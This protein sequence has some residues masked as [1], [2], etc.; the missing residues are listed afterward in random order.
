MLLR[1]RME[2]EMDAELRF[3]IEAYADDLARRGISREEALRRARI[4]FGGVERVKEEGREARGVRLLEEL[5]QDLRYGARMFRKSPG[6]T[7]VAI[8][9]L[10]LGIGAN[11][12]IF[13]VVNAVLLSP[14]PYADAHRLILVKEVLPNTSAEPFNVSGPDIAEIQRLNHV[15]E[16][17]GGFRVWTYEFSGRG[18]PARVT[19]NR[20]SSNLFD[21]LGVQPVAGRAF[22][23]QEEQFGHQVVVLSYG[24]WQRQFGGQHDVLGQTINLDRKPYTIVGVMP[25]SFVFPLPG[26]MQGVAADLWVPLGL[27]KEELAN[28][29]DNLSYTVVGRL[30]P[31]I[32]PGQVNADLQLVARGV[33]ETYQRWSR[34]ASQPLGD[35]RLG[36]VSVP[37]R[38]EVTGPLK[39]MLLMLLGAVG[40]V[41]LIACVNVANLLMMRSVGRQKE[42]AVRLAIGAGR[43]RLLRQLLVECM[44][45]AF[46]GGGLG[47]ALAVW[48]KDVLV[49]HMPASVPQF[50]AIEHDWTV[51]LFSFLLVTFA[52]LAFSALPALWASRTDFSA[53]L[54]ESGRGNSQGPDHQRLRAAFVIVEVALSAMLLV[55]AGLMVRSFQRVLNTNPGFRPEHVLTASIDLPPTEEYSQDEKVASF[56]KQLMEKLRQTPGIA[57]AGAST[58]LP[59]L[60]GWTHAF[61]VEGYQPPPGPELSLGHHSVIYGDY[62]QT[63]GI[64]LLQGRYFTEQD[65]P[66][67]THVLIVSESLA[68]K[69]WSGQNP[70]GKRLK[71]GPPESTDPW[72]TVV[73]IVGNVKQGPLETAT[74]THTYEPYAQ[75]GVPFSLRVAVRGQGDPARLAANVRAVVWSLD[76]QLALGS[77]RTMD[78]V[79]SRSTAS[80]RF[81]LVLLGAFAA[82]ALVLAAIGIYAVLAYSVA[83][84]THEIG[85]RMALGARTGDV[86][87]LVLGQGLRLTAIGI[88]FGVAGALVLTRFLQS[89]LYEVQPTDPPTFVGA[90]LMLVGVSVAAGYLPARRAVRVDP[91]VALRYE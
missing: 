54:Q 41:L 13:S 23:P 37:L 8:L 61:T 3:H 89:L 52:G 48:F 56:Y 4:E 88:V 86:V 79:I 19:A 17:V 26:M 28:F 39:P 71:W 83:R 57:T 59:L 24:F 67:T 84:R 62:L 35:F 40:F 72:L 7:A 11:A 33:L 74:D 38:D 51:L 66:K 69:Y 85:V 6:F 73:G 63:M 68:E 58:D 14:L 77:V 43:L 60:G 75:L 80:R 22:E 44:L 65:G 16:V 55:G 47:L 32:Q 42:M 9:T 90:L 78:E 2:G 29:G 21:V 27:S 36:M 53:S 34:E 46:A 91:M 31:G 76:R 45:L 25:Q 1:S 81:S 18:E 30:R 50:H 10:A 12:A 87:R 5:T 20:I 70:L 64:P 82:L 15:F 49:A